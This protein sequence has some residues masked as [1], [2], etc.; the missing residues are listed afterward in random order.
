MAASRS[1]D[2]FVLFSVLWIAG[3]LAVIATTFAIS[4]RLHIKSQANLAQ[5]YQAEVA[6]DGLAR[7]VGYRLAWANLT[8]STAS[9][10]PLDGKLVSCA[11]GDAAA[12]RGRALIAVQDQAG[13]IDL[14]QTSPRVLTDVLGRL[15]VAGADEVSL[16][17]VDFRDHDESLYGG[18][19][20]E[21]SLVDGGPGLKNAAF[22]SVDELAQ[23]VPERLAK[24][25]DLVPFFTV[26]ALQEGIDPAV[27][28]AKL[29]PLVEPASASTGD[30]GRLPSTLSPRKAFAI[31]AEVTLPSGVTFRRMAVISLLRLPDRPY[32]LLE[33][34]QGDMPRGEIHFASPALGCGVVG[35][36][37][38]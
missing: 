29:K 23:A 36:S 13:L 7:L 6:A 1:D 2:G 20:D 21:V 38:V 15:G 22:Q 17:I 27:A 35:S 37:K 31:D 9:P 33:W 19:G 32:A 24:V 4:T 10:V 3:L 25:A 5:A 34:R 16:A 12:G 30:G 26:Y 28:P 11:L 18:G 8:D 14:N